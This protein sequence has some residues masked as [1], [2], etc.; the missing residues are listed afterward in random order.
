MIPY[1][2]EIEYFFASLTF[3]AFGYIFV[4]FILKN[5]IVYDLLFQ[6]IIN[7]LCEFIITISKRI[8]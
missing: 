3:Y 1:L 7:L 4:N 8:L 5:N 6:E 2:P